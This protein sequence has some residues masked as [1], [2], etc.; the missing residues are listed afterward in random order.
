MSRGK[1]RV[2]KLSEAERQAKYERKAEARKQREMIALH[3]PFQRGRDDISGIT[4]NDRGKRIF[5]SG[6][7]AVGLAIMLA[8]ETGDSIEEV[9]DTL[10]G[11]G[12]LGLLKNGKPAVPDDPEIL[13]QLP[14]DLREKLIQISKAK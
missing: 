3:S 1:Q 5:G 13:A 14:A 9:I 7:R 8:N 6:D 4:L 11:L 10:E 12:Q 2:P